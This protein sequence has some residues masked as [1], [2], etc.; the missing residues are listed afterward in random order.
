MAWGPGLLRLHVVSESLIALA[1]LMASIALL[2]IIHRRRGF[3]FNGILY[4]FAATAVAFAIV[5]EMQAIMLA[6]PNNWG[7]V[8]IKAATAAI[9]VV[10]LIVL[11][12][13]I[14]DV[15]TIPDRIADHRFQEL[16][17]N[18]P[19]AIMQVDAKGTI[20]IANQTAEQMFGYGH[21]ELIGCNVDLLVPHAH[22]AA[23][24]AEV[25]HFVHSGAYRRV[26][27]G[28]MDRHGLRK[29]G[30]EFSVEIGLSPMKTEH[31]LLITAVIRD[32]T[33]RKQLERELE[34]ERDLRG[35]RNEVLARLAAELAHEIKNPLAIIHAR[36]SDLREMA[37][38]GA[39]LQTA[40]VAQTCD[41][42][43][44]TTERAIRVIRGVEA[45][46]H[47]G[48]HDPMQKTD[49]RT[50]I[51]QSVDL[52]RARYE[53]HGISLEVIIPDDLPMVECREVQIEQILVNLLTNAFDAIEADQSSMR[54]VQVRVAMRPPTGEID[55]AE[56]VQ[57]DVVDGGP[58]ILPEIRGHLM[59]TFFTTKPKGAGMGIGLSVSRTI[60]E[61]HGGSLVLMPP[62]WPTCFR[63]TL[64][65]LS[66]RTEGS[67]T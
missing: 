67:S 50:M 51:E 7:I 14:P 33:D 4:C 23:H 24:G 13:V 27:K 28:T 1:C 8:S 42:I 9:L 55:A 38:D 61:D 49:V 48:S 62:D 3:R 16:M 2:R 30:S 59:E 15:F 56:A 32:V 52:L 46:A 25:Q 22:R 53:T 17:D 19:D 64:P 63:L 39:L 10:T 6:H 21:K 58:G 44:K 29:D 18:A 65:V 66:A 35:Q 34:R 54:W 57:I 20:I 41:S 11:V 45:L 43:V 31:G 37:T 60:A 47:R 26:D 36:A 40:F 12:R 5:H